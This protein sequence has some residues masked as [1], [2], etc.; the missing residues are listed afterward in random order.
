MDFERIELVR[1]LEERTP[2]TDKEMLQRFA[3][4]VY[5][6]ASF[7]HAEINCDE[8]SGSKKANGSFK[9]TPSLC[10]S[11][12]LHTTTGHCDLVTIQNAAHNIMWAIKDG[13]WRK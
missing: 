9:N 3:N 13:K 2:E 8:L 6:D 1:V 10:K 12:K 4:Q 5:K 11:C 7:I